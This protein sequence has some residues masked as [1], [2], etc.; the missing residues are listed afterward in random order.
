MYGEQI[1]GFA[2][3]SGVAEAMLATNFEGLSVYDETDVLSK[4]TPED[5]MNRLSDFDIN[6]TSVSIINPAK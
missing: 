2:S 4:I 6:N 3:V 1:R 5:I